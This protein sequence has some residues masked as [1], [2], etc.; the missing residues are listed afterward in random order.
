MTW[1]ELI[2][3]V[4]K[5]WLQFGLGLAAGF[6]GTTWG[7]MKKLFCWRKSINAAMVSILHDRLLSESLRVL[8]AGECTA[9]EW[10]NLQLMYKSYAELGG[11]GT[12]KTLMGRVGQYVKIVEHPQNEDEGR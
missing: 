12:I 8:D 7:R 3:T 11:N 10:E 4:Q 9:E 1:A 5:Y 2:E 6:L